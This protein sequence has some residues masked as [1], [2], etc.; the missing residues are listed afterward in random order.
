MAFPVTS[1]LPLSEMQCAV[2]RPTSQREARQAA[3]TV[4]AGA[5]LTDTRPDAHRHT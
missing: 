2:Q 4:P 3:N 1:Y 5:A